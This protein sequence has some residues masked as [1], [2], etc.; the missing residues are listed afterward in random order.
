MDTRISGKTRL[1]GVFGTPITHSGSP[2]MYNFSFD[3]YGIDGVYLAFDC[4]ESEMKDSLAAMRRLNMWGANVTMPCKQEAARN[5][6]RLSPAAK[7]IGAVNTIVNDGGILT[8]H[9]TDGMGVVLDLKDHGKSVQDQKIVLLG[10]GGAATAIMVQCALDGAKSVT[11]FNRGASALEKA[12]KIG[13]KMKKEGVSCMLDYCL[14][15]EE[16]LLTETI[17]QGDILINATSVGM[18]PMSEGQSLITDMK[19]FHEELVVYDVIY[20]PEVTKLMKDAAE[21]GCR[22]ENIIGGKGMLLWQGA[23]AFRLYTGL[24]MPVRELKE[25]L[26]KR[27]KE[28]TPVLQDIVHEQKE[29]HEE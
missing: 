14:L 2:V 9:N 17:R 27:E 6:D 28:G 21:N 23:C 24:E 3:Y 11:V 25:F 15:S 13:K 7:F 29:Y 16:E 4:R 10:A 1:L 19:A 5:M 26:A 8:G 12:E 20:N 22:K 18:A